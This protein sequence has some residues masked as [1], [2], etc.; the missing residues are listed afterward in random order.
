MMHKKA[1]KRYKNLYKGNIDKKSQTTMN[2]TKKKIINEN[3][4]DSSGFDF[5]IIDDDKIEKGVER[6]RQKEKFSPQIEIIEEKPDTKIEE[7]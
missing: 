6:Y 4:I 2:N 3:N 7:F 5:S 1:S